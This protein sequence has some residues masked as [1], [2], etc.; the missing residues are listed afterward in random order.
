VFLR[1]FLDTEVSVSKCPVTL[2]KYLFFYETKKIRKKFTKPRRLSIEVYSYRLIILTDF[3]K[4]SRHYCKMGCRRERVPETVDLLCVDL[5]LIIVLS[6][7]SF[8]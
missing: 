4:G 5:R 6:R 1:W 2:S 8:T 3:I 7:V